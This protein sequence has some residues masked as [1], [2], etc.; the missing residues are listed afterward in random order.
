MPQPRKEQVKNLKTKYARGPASVSFT[1]GPVQ[2]VTGADYTAVLAATRTGVDDGAEV[3]SGAVLV[4]GQGPFILSFNSSFTMILAGVNAGLPITVAFV[5]ADFVELDANDVMTTS[6]TAAKINSV[7]AGF[8][9]TVPV[10]QN[11]DGRLILRSADSSGFTYGDTAFMSMA[12]VTP[13]TLQVF[14][15]SLTNQAASNGTTA[16]KRGLITS[17]RDGQGGVVQIRNL[18]STPSEPQNPAMIQVAPYR[19]IPEVLPGRPAYARVRKIPVGTPGLELTYYRTG[20][21][22]PSVV[23]TISNFT[24]LVITDQ[25]DIALN[26]GNGTTVSFPMNLEDVATVPQ[27]IDAINLAYRNATLALPNSVEF[28]RAAVPLGVPGPYVFTDPAT[29]DSFYVSF[30]GNT[31]IHINPPANQYSATSLATYINNQIA[32]AA[33]FAEGEAV[34]V[35]LSGVFSDPE[36]VVIRSKNL[37]GQTSSVKFHPGNPGAMLAVPGTFME[38]LNALGV[39]P[40]LYKATFVAAPYGLDEIEIFCPSS[41]SAASVTVTPVNAPSGTK[42]GIPVAVTKTTTVGQARVTVPSATVVLP[43]MV[44]FHEEPD[45]YD[46]DVLEFENRGDS[47]ELNP[48]DGIGNI[49]LQA[50]L[51]QTGKIDPS[52]I[53]RVLESLAMGQQVLGANR[54]DSTVDQLSAR[55]LYPYNSTF[56]ATLLWQGVALDA[57]GVGTS[58]LV[59][60]YLF[61]GDIYLTKNAKLDQAGLW[62]FD[63]SGQPASL[64]EFHSGKGAVAAWTAADGWAHSDWQRNVK[65][66]PFGA[67]EGQYSDAIMA[68]GEFQSAGASALKARIEAPVQLEVPT[69]LFAAKGPSGILVRA[70]VSVDNIAQKSFLEITVN[71]SYNG[72]QYV[73]DVTGLVAVRYKFGSFA[74]FEMSSRLAANNASWS[75]WDAT[76][77][78]ADPASLITFFG[79]Q[80]RPG[81]DLQDSTTPRISVPRYVPSTNRRT[82]LFESPIVDSNT[83]VPIRIYLDTANT[84][85]GEGFTFTWNA[86]W[87]H[88]IG[89]WTQD[90]PSQRSYGWAMV[91]QR[92]WFFSKVSGAIPWGDGFNNW[93]SYDAFDR[94]GGTSH[95]NGLVMKD[96]VLRVDAPSVVSNPTAQTPVL[97]NALYA[98]TMIKS[99]ARN[100]YLVPN[101]AILDGFN[102]AVLQNW[103]IWDWYV[104]N[105]TPL[106]NG[107]YTAIG[108]VEFN[109]S[110]SATNPVSQIIWGT[111]F[112]DRISVYFFNSLG[113]WV[114]TTSVGVI[115]MHLVLKATT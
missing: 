91:T 12:D 4:G 76:T 107:S 101:P 50:L 71:A 96:G 37:N 13:G 44:E 83:A 19:F 17:S 27:V 42:W 69:L 62:H 85:A 9:V 86:K 56:G 80:I 78:R 67:A 7:L 89:S 18:D 31:P 109:G 34:A 68:L 81:N 84:I 61:S 48:Q 57:S 77:V 114:D 20:P 90:V 32:G 43:E 111:S 54:L 29:R 6:R 1:G 25:L 82:L 102:V 28:T 59:R 99:W 88:S 11:V 105:A 21:V 87:D 108:S 38:T 15:F 26:F 3:S 49:G 70:Y 75:A 41:L 92:F 53:P 113:N 106:G 63:V 58:G 22:R 52:F 65:F 74:G 40:G 104:I 14:G 33:Q 36:H 98:K 5:E 47:A 64:F 55:T 10:A 66:N 73:K 23:T 35:S 2:N 95:N 110:Q 39:T 72:T 100:R 51:G 112:S 103:T 79:G 46:T 97:L 30:N 16:P 45:T 24:A 94:P 93:D 115:G 8:G 60:V